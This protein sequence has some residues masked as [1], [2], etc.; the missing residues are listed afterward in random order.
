MKRNN[1]QDGVHTAAKYLIDEYNHQ[2]IYN[3]ELGKHNQT[4]D[5]IKNKFKE[6]IGE[7]SYEYYLTGKGNYNP[8]KI[9]AFE[10]WLNDEGLS[11]FR[12]NN[13]TSFDHLNRLNTFSRNDIRNNVTDLSSYPTG[14]DA[15][16]HFY[17]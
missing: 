6:L 13:R 9:E 2:R 5:R 12:F 16:T 4:S 3:E 14:K 8:I 17:N 1:L 10:K 15:I 11:D 7:D